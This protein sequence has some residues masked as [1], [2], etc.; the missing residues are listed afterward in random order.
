MKDDIGDRFKAYESAFDFAL[1]PRMPMIVRVDGRAF[2]SLPLKKPFDHEFGA[3]MT[4]V[5]AILCERSQGAVLAYTQ[6]DEVSVVLRDDQRYESQAWF[7][8]RLSKVVS[9][10][11]AIATAVFASTDWAGATF[12]SR[13]FVL[14]DLNEVTNYLIWRQKDA[15]RNAIQMAARSRWSQKQL[16]GKST[17]DLVEM[18]EA[19][20]TPM[21]FFPAGFRL[22]RVVYRAPGERDWRCD[23]APRFVDARAWVATVYA[24]EER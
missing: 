22:G 5:A 24:R 10:S 9:A 19:A 21:E 18:L 16:H 6:S 4:T 1:P 2:H 15:Q 20:A 3:A 7:G 8:K 13:A 12:D 17:A 23:F 14:P 11:A